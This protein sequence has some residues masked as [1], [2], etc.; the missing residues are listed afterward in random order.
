MLL[1]GKIKPVSIPN[2]ARMLSEVVQNFL[3]E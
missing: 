2:T 3:D 1:N